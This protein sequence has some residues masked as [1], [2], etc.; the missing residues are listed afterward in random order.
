MVSAFEGALVELADA[1]AADTGRRRGTPCWPSAAHGE[2][3][4]AA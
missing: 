1:V 3:Y 2:A 4:E